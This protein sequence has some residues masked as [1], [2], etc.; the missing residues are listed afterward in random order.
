MKFEQIFDYGCS[1]VWHYPLVMLIRSL[2]AKL[3]F[4]MVREFYAKAPDYWQLVE[5]KEPFL[6]KARDFFTDTPPNCDP[7]V[8]L[9]LDLF[10]GLML[11]GPWAWNRRNGKEFLRHIEECARQSEAE[12]QFLAVL[13]LNSRVRAFW[14]REGFSSTG[15]SRTITIGDIHTK[16]HRL[17]KNL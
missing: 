9:R 3:D 6:Q 10:L 11:L 15:S 8:S 4:A 13:G 16:I 14:E 12:K 1:D 2:V 17:I 7:K 5:G